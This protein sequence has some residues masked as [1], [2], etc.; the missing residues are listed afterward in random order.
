MNC[1]RFTAVELKG[2]MPLENIPGLRERLEKY[3]KQEFPT[4][5]ALQE[6]GWA[7]D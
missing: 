4:F 3:D 5:E 2:E 1:R 6:A 7:I